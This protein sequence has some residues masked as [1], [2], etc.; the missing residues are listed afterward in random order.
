[1]T[2]HNKK[3]A[4]GLEKQFETIK[5]TRWAKNTRIASSVIWNLFLLFLVIGLTLTVFGASVGAGYFASLVAKEPLRPK[6]EMRS[7]IFS[8]EETSEIY[9]NGKYLRKVRSDIDRKEVKLEDVSPF[10]IMQ[11]M[12]RKMNIL[13]HIMELYQKQFFVDFSKML[14]TLTA[15][16]VVRH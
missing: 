16:Q 15:K 2:N 11:Y 13:L 7:E 9:T 10:V 6:E 12:Q 1:M 5:K 14:R 3:H 8:Y 4:D